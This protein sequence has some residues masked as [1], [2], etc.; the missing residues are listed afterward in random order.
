MRLWPA[1]QRR[2]VRGFSPNS[3]ATEA[4][5]LCERLAHLTTTPGAGSCKQ[6]CRIS[7]AYCL[8]GAEPPDPAQALAHSY[9]FVQRTSSSAA[10]SAVSKLAARFAAGGGELAQLVRKDQDLATEAEA[11]DKTV[12]AFVS[13]PPA[14]RS[15]AAEEQVR[16]R[17]AEVKAE[18]EKL[19]QI[20]NDRSP[21]Y[22]A[23]SKPLPVTVPET[24]ALLADDEA[25][26]V[27][28]WPCRPMTT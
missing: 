6:A 4:S 25:L 13:K 9:E 10:A 8:A 27:R 23:L 16:K 15:A 18:R 2:M 20:I 26:V 17:I 1:I 22:A 19:Q 7:R 5:T 3:L 11:L 21:D 14:Q 24:Q 12:V 28:E